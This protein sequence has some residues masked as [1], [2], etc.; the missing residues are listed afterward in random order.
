MQCLIYDSRPMSVGYG[1]DG[2]VAVITL[3][4][5]DRFN[6]IEAT[7][8]AELVDAVGRA[9]VESRAIVLTGSGR[10][11]C[12]GAD[13]A[14]LIADYDATGPDLGDRL[15]R[16]FHPMIDALI[17][18][19]VPTVAAVNGVAAGAGLGLALACDLRV[20]GESASFVSAFSGIGL[21]PDSGTTWGLPAVVGVGRALE[22]ALT[23]RRLNAVEAVDWGLCAEV[24]ND[25]E[26]V[27]RA[28]ELAS[29]LAELVPDAL[30]TTRRLIREAPGK[31]FADALRA[32]REEQARLGRT[33]AH[34]EGVRAFLE[35][36]KP[37]YRLTR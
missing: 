13:L 22:M 37:D 16:V 36:R 10:A 26:L 23:N 25:G 3:A 27:A 31:P 11:F 5:P 15:D 35:K 14:D 29:T 4:R 2:D 17:Q 12:S 32:E 28:T 33:P 19:H 24:V 18:A 1:L 20:A 7:L 30:V 8:S 21:V 9:N 34:L 6:A